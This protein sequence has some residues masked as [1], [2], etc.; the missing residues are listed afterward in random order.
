MTKINFIMTK[1]TLLIAVLTLVMAACSPLNN[2]KVLNGTA[3]EYT[4]PGEWEEHEGT[5]LIWPHNYGIIV[6]EYVDMID[7]IWVTMTKALHTGDLLL[8]L[9]LPFLGIDRQ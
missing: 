5:W 9:F 8:G 4:L 6:S 1:C 2:D 3:V 7:D